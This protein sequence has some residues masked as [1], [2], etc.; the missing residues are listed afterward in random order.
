MKT[1]KPAISVIICTYNRAELLADVLQ[2]VCEQS[3]PYSDYEV[4]VVDNNSTDETAIVCGFFQAR[5]SHVR[6]CFEPRQGLS[7]AR[8]RGWQ[9]AQGEYVAYI[10]DDCKV[11]SQWLAVA[12]EIIATERPVEFGGPFYAFYNVSKP[13]WWSEEYDKL[14]SMEYASSA[15]YLPPSDEIFGGNLFLLRVALQQIGG[16]N[17]DLGMSGTAIGYGEESEV[18]IRLGKAFPGHRA[19]YEPRLFVYHLVRAE[20]LSAGWTLRDQITAGKYYYLTYHQ[21]PTRFTWWKS[22][23]YPL[24]LL[25]IF[26]SHTMRCFLFRN[27]RQYPTWQ[28]Y[29]YANTHLHYYCQQ[30][31]L[32]Y[33]RARIGSQHKQETVS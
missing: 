22:I 32:L 29:V 30:L 12:A 31:G 16:F 11:P 15:G 4:I 21:S 27:R 25:L 17:P 19:F 9:E 33:T 10:D 2:T 3:L 5:Y 8:N 24:Y 26:A 6:I 18:H 23:L 1:I 14:H 7:H 13:S 28:N 20:K